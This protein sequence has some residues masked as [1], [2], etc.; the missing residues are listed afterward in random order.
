[1]KKEK[2]PKFSIITIVFNDARNIDRTIQSV[3]SQTYPEIEYIIIDGGST[4]GTVEI[5]KK[6]GDVISHWIS[7]SDNGIYDAMNKGLEAATGDYVWF[8]N[9]GDEIYDTNTVNDLCT[10][11]EPDGDIYYGEAMYIDRYGNEVGLRSSVTPH[12]LP[13]Q[14]RWQHMYRGMVVCHQSFIVKRTIAPQYDLRYPHSGDIDWIIRCLKKSKRVIN[15]GMVLSKYL[16]GGHSKEF[17]LR[18]LID[19]YKVLQRHFGVLPNF[20]NHIAITIRALKFSSGK[21]S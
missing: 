18:S 11:C 4:D 20:V 21:K 2:S 16:I 1:M 19:R 14:L 3:A 8:I 6:H 7:E 9:S 5:I 12:Q 13:E 17:H 10:Q 15:T